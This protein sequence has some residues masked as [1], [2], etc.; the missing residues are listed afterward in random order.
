MSLEAKRV[1]TDHLME[2][3]RELPSGREMPDVV[4]TIASL[5]DYK[6]ITATWRPKCSQ[7]VIHNVTY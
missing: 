5:Q 4:P 2:K 7:P 6:S 3:R 1:G